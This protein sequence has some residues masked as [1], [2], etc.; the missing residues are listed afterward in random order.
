VINGSNDLLDLARLKTVP[1]PG[2]PDDAVG[3]LAVSCSQA[4]LFLGQ[5]G[6]SFTVFN[7]A[8]SRLN[9]AQLRAGAELAIES[10]DVVRNI[11][12]WNGYCDV[13][14]TVSG[15]GVPANVSDTV[16]LRVAPIVTRHHLHPPLRVY[17]TP[18][19]GDSAQDSADFL[20]DLRAALSAS[21][22][23]AP[24]FELDFEDPWTQDV[25][26][27]AYMSMPAA[28]APHVM[29]VTSGRRTRAGTAGTLCAPAAGWSSPSCAAPTSRASR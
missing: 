7:P 17:A 9:A 27:T 12:S 4:R 10:K 28:G 16:R 13:T 2:A 6:G 5:G 25:F 19:G 29:H 24:L 14:L 15:T 23:V 26:E 3:A 21:G 22:V 11:A 1:W 18:V 8:T 20:Y